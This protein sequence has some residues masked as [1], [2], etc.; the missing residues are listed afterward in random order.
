M[1][2]SK[3]SGRRREAAVYMSRAR[4]DEA[5]L[6]LASQQ[7]GWHLTAKENGNRS[8]AVVLDEG[9]FDPNG[10]RATPSFC[11]GAGCRSQAWENAAK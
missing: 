9:A 1:P 11:R 3:P 4:N 8:K 7:G 10:V 6:R 2:E 5:M